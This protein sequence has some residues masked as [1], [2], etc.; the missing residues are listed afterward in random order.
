MKI[1]S[2]TTKNWMG[3]PDG[4]IEPGTLT[5]FSG[6][7]GSGKTSKIE[8]LRYCV[9]SGHDPS[10]IRVGQDSAEVEIKTDDG[11]TLKVVVNQKRTTRAITDAKGKKAGA[12]FIHTLVSELSVDP[13][14]FLDMAPKEQLSALLAAIPLRVTVQDLAFMPV[15]HLRGKNLDQHALTVL[16]DIR[17]DLYE[18]RTGVNRVA[19][20]KRITASQMTATLPP[21]APAGKNWKGE[22]DRLFTENKRL[23]EEL[24]SRSD[25][26]RDDA[27]SAVESQRGLCQA[28]KDAINEGFNTEISR[29]RADLEAAIAK[30]R[31]GFEIEISLCESQRD[32]VISASENN[33]NEALASLE[34]ELRPRINQVLTDGREAKTMFEQTAKAE[35]TR[36]FVATL[37]GDADVLDSKGNALT[38]AIDKVD[39]LKVKLASELPIPGLEITPDGLTLDGIPFARVNKAKQIQVALSVAKLQAGEFGLVVLDDCEHLDTKSLASFEEAAQ[40]SGLQFVAARVTD[41]EL[42]VANVG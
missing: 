31:K 41:S 25:A 30:L 38:A 13:I 5:I 4:T 24:K 11:N 20:E 36:T 8:A 2:F 18:E 29:Y 7:N 37:K 22:F 32:T 33:R 35:T 14:R 17:K 40:L 23:N 21:E 28:K 34:S 6:R 12:E 10:V 42:E 3:A 19:K 39:A 26:I 1:K 27:N 15:D 16:A 9:G